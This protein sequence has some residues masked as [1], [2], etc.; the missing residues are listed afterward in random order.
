MLDG[1]MQWAPFVACLVCALSVFFTLRKWCDAI[2]GHIPW[3]KN[4]CG[5]KYWTWI[6]AVC[7]L[8]CGSM[9]MTL[10]RSALGV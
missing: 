5:N 3:V 6:N 1:A 8:L 4:L 10:F 2:L 7:A 9:L